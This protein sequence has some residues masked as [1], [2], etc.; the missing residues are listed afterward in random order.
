MSGAGS[1]D[2]LNYN[3]K[4]A[5]LVVSCDKYSDLW[6]PFFDLFFKYW[7]DC[8]LKIYLLSNDKSYDDTRV[9][10]ILVGEDE[11]WSDNLR[12]AIQHIKENFIFMFI[13]DLFL[14]DYVKTDKV[15]KTF[16]WM[17]MHQPNYVRLNP[18]ETPDKPFNH[19]V[20][21]VS[22]GTIYR[23]STVMSVWKKEL[24]LK[25]LMPGENAWEFEIDGSIRSDG[26]E[27]FYSTWEFLFP[28]ENGVIKGKWQRRIAKK[29]R[30]L[31]A[32]PDLNKRAVMNRGD[33]IIFFLKVYRTKLLHVFPAKYRRGI[34]NFVSDINFNHAIDK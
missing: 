5:L 31:G 17:I 18:S 22:K 8:P 1:C 15:L 14:V 26:Y 4:I 16:D 6:K 19:L 25:L 12:K 21:I 13:D 10:S 30:A 2:S 3:N 34:K 9:S 28:V 33:A 23:T 32:I 11:S 27:G 24:L 29:I 20:G 7:Y